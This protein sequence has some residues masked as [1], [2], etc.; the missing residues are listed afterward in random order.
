MRKFRWLLRVLLVAGIAQTA[1][2]ASPELHYF[3]SRPIGRAPFPTIVL[4]HDCRGL[5]PNLPLIQIYAAHFAQA[6][7]VVAVPDSFFYRPHG[8]VCADR[9]EVPYSV[10]ARD[11]Y[12][13]LD[14]LI[15]DGVAL[16]NRTIVITMSERRNLLSAIE[17]AAVDHA[18][19]FQVMLDITDTEGSITA[20]RNADLLLN[21][22]IDG[23]RD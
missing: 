19:R 18:H 9:A 20:L 10:Q 11:A 7:Y 14:R 5:F 1:N 23:A 4:M 15:A 8:D 16:P 6:G 13:V 17:A 2:A 21:K 22:A 12:D 3:I